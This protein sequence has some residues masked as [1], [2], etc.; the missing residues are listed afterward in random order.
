MEEGGWLNF[1]LGVGV[2]LVVGS[3]GVLGGFR[4]CVWKDFCLLSGD[5]EFWFL[6]LLWGI[7]GV[8]IVKCLK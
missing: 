1:K 4:F 2:D 3:F 5:F 8:F 7:D 6:R